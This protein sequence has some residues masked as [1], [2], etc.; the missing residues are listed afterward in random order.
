MSKKRRRFSREFK[1][2]AVRLVDE[3]GHRQSDVARDLEIRSELIRRWR[4][5]L[6]DD[7][8]HAFPGEGRLKPPEEDV[9]RLQRENRRLREEREIFKKALAI[10]SDRRRG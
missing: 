4:K 10:F 8:E 5:Q 2:E 1:I 3:C 7:P 9:R 6:R